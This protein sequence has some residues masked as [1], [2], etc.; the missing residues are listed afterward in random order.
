MDTNGI[1]MV[2]LLNQ[3]LLF[4]NTGRIEL[5]SRYFSDIFTTLL[6]SSWWWVLFITTAVYIG[7]WIIFGIFY[8]AFAIANNDYAKIKGT[9]EFAQNQTDSIEPCVSDVYDM[10]SAFLFSMES[11]TTIG[12][13]FQW[14]T[15]TKI[16][17]IQIKSFIMQ[18]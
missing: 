1:F 10:T 5:Y 7:H 15:K 14:P 12:K 18:Y 6:D 9:I 13:Y 17:P 8:L 11:E 3:S 4:Q 2:S 16:L